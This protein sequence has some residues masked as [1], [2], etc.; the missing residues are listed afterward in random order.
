MGENATMTGLSRFC[1]CEWACVRAC[2]RALRGVGLHTGEGPR[3]VRWS[4]RMRRTAGT[5]RKPGRTWT[6]ARKRLCAGASSS[7]PRGDSP[8]SP[9][10][11]QHSHPAHTPPGCCPSLLS[12]PTAALLHPARRPLRRR[13]RPPTL[14]LCLPERSVPRLAYV[15]PFR[16]P[17]GILCMAASGTPQLSEPTSVVHSDHGHLRTALQAVLVP[18]LVAL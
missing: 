9:W 2:V 3:M 14:S 16:R 18:V 8:T 4:T 7:A 10:L 13:R 1:A 5:A 17:D 11:T 12:S 6:I 15:S